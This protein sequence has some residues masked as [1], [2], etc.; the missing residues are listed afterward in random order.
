[1]TALLLAAGMT[2]A[3]VLIEG[4]VFG[5]GN[6]SEVTGNTTVTIKGGTIGD[7]LRLRHRLL[8]ANL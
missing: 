8:D 5:G 2:Q 4:N 1:M 3:Q 7:T 6:V